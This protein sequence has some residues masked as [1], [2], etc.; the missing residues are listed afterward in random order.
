MSTDGTSSTSGV[1]TPDPRQPGGHG[2]PQE[3]H[4]RYEIV[5]TLGRGG[6][7]LAVRARDRE[8]GREVVLKVLDF[9]EL[10]DWKDFELW[11]R[12]SQVLRSLDHPAIPQFIGHF[13]QEI[14]G[15]APE[16][17]VTVQEF[18]EGT[19]LDVLL[20]EREGPLMDEEE[21]RAFLVEMLGVLAYFHSLNPPV[22]HRDIKPSNI[23]RR[24][25]GSHALIDFG[26]AQS[27]TEL[28][29]STTFVGTNGYMPPEQ[30][31][32]RAETRSDLYALGATVV[33]LVSGL[34]P[35]DLAEAGMKLDLSHAPVSDAFRQV[36]ARLTD[37]VPERRYESAS[38]AREVLASP[39]GA[40]VVSNEAAEGFKL[41]KR[42]DGVTAI[43]TQ[44][45]RGE[46]LVAA[47]VL[48]FVVAAISI[49][50][51]TIVFHGLLFLT[52]VMFLRIALLGQQILL[53]PDG[54]GVK[55]VFGVKTWRIHEIVDVR[56]EKTG[57]NNKTGVESGRVVLLTSDAKTHDFS[58]ALPLKLPVSRMLA[59]TINQHVE[60]LR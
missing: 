56:S 2:L 4:A 24:P 33:E 25:D 7:G 47:L 13:P 21:A 59:K 52:V 8:T 19:S 39:G 23:V 1:N 11:Q 20:A 28:T 34:H 26:A 16:I 29:G 55:T 9:I 5:E 50:M 12:E 3:V 42:A 30:L 17:V 36:L 49:N 27:S 38:R 44:N 48:G 31:M 10:T 60:S 14:S 15:A 40:L 45:A 35:T 53:L 22:V 43:T 41:V 37:P 54:L 32:G 58:R 18:V 57:T 51:P 46:S 6:Q